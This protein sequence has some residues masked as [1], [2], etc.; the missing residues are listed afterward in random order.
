MAADMAAADNAVDHP[1]ADPVEDPVDT[2]AAGSAGGSVGGRA[3]D[4]PG[5]GPVDKADS[6]DIGP[7]GEVMDTEMDAEDMA[8]TGA[9]PEIKHA[10]NAYAHPNPTSSKR[11]TSCCW[12]INPQ[13]S[14]P[15]KG[16]PP[17]LSTWSMSS[18]APADA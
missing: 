6:V 4:A 1:V 18:R 11:T 2:P 17:H 8:T 3:A 12:S 9:M 14:P 7:V 13:A 5:A 10:K 16:N 15:A